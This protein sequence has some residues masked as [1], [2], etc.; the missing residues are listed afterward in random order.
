MSEDERN[1]LEYKFEELETRVNKLEVAIGELQ[2][3]AKTMKEICAN[4]NQ[5]MDCTAEFVHRFG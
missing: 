1:Y 3:C 2:N 4:L 5:K